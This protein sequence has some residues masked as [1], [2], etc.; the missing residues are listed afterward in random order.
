MKKFWLV[1]VSMLL[2]TYIASAQSSVAMKYITVKGNATE[3]VIPDEVF[4]RV[5]LREYDRKPAGTVAISEIITDF[6]NRLA[7]LSISE[8]RVF[9]ESFYGQN[10]FRRRS[11]ATKMKAYVS[12]T[13]K[14]HTTA[15]A[16]KFI[17]ALNDQA[18][19]S[20]HITHFSY[21]KEKELLSALQA[22]AILAAEKNATALASAVRQTI[23]DPIAIV[24]SGAVAYAPVVTDAVAAVGTQSGV[25][26]EEAARNHYQWN[27]IKYNADVT[28]SFEMRSK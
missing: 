21:S 17:N 11:T 16:E 9:T 20:A 5:V 25:A 26:N 13:V 3:E 18:T 14:L 2:I 27:K 28:V 24:G 12:Y 7:K 1:T 8:D 6:Q 4:V 22:K 19:E 15:E 10:L 23:G